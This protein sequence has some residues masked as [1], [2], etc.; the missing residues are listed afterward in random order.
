MI[1][2]FSYWRLY[3]AL[4]HQLPSSSYQRSGLI[5]S[6]ITRDH[7]FPRNAEFW[8]ELRNLPISLE[9]LCF[10]R[11]LW[12]L[13]LAGDIGDKYGIFWWSSDR[14]TRFHNEIHDCH[15]GSDGRNTKNIELS[16]SQILPVK[17]VDRLYLSVAITGDKY[18]IFGQVQ[19]P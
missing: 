10:H 19:R 15:S 3:Q 1:K 14:H 11:I 8:A 2:R 13:V 18:C 7:S 5:W 17:L 6:V 9:F 4:G 16:L 12:N